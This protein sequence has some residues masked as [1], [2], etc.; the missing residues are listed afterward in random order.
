QNQNMAQ[1]TCEL[2]LLSCFSKNID[3][4]G[5]DLV[6]ISK[7]NVILSIQSSNGDVAICQANGDHVKNLA[8][9]VQRHWWV[10]N[11]IVCLKQNGTLEVYGPCLEENDWNIVA[12]MTQNDIA[13]LITQHGGPDMEFADINLLSQYNHCAI[14]ECNREHI[15][16]VAVSQEGQLK[17]LAYYK[18]LLMESK[19]MCQRDVIVELDGDSLYFSIFKQEKRK[20]TLSIKD[21]LKNHKQPDFTPDTF[22]NV[23]LSTDL[24]YVV[25]MDNVEGHIVTIDIR[26]YIAKWKIIENSC[27]YEQ[28]HPAV[29]ELDSESVQASRISDATW[30]NQLGDLYQRTNTHASKSRDH[31]GIASKPK[32]TGFKLK[33][34][35]MT[36]STQ[37][38][39]IH[40]PGDDVTLNDVREIHVDDTA[41]Y[42]IIQKMEAPA[43]Y[44]CCYNIKDGTW[45]KFRVDPN[46]GVLFSHNSALPHLVVSSS[47]FYS[48]TV[49][50][51]Q[52]RLINKLMVYGSAGLADVLCRLNNWECHSI[53]MHTLEIGLKHR[54]LDTVL[55]FLS[56]RQ[57]DLLAL[58]SSLT[59]T[60]TTAKHVVF[61]DMDIFH[62]DAIIAL[63]TTTIQENLSDHQSLQFGQQL[64]RITLSY[65]HTLLGTLSEIHDNY[66]YSQPVGHL[67]ISA[68]K[69][70][71]NELQGAMEKLTSNI[72]FLRTLL[73]TPVARDDVVDGVEVFEENFP[74]HWSHMS[75]EAVICDGIIE[76]NIP[77]VQC[78]LAGRFNTG[79]GDIA[80]IVNVGLQWA[81]KHISERE[82]QTARTLFTNL[83][84]D[85]TSK[86]RQVCF[87]TPYKSLRD[88]LIEEL[89]SKGDL[90]EFELGM[91][92]YLHKLEA[93]YS[94]VSFDMAKVLRTDG[95]V[96]EW[97]DTTHLKDVMSQMDHPIG[98][99][100]GDLVESDLANSQT[101]YYSHMLL[102]WLRG[103]DDA[104]R[105]SVLIERL[106]NTKD[107][108]NEQITPDVMLDYLVRHNATEALLAW[109]R[110]G[111][112][113]PGLDVTSERLDSLQNCSDY[114]RN[115][116][117]D[118]AAR[119][120]VFSSDECQ[121][122]SK[123]LKRQAR[124][125]NVIAY[126]KD[127][128]TNGDS[129]VIS[130][131][132]Y[133]LHFI[134]MCLKNKL[135]PLLY[136]YVDFHR[137][138]ED[139]C[140]RIRGILTEDQRHSWTTLISFRNLG[141]CGS[142]TNI[143]RTSRHL[144]ESLF[145]KSPISVGE[146]F[147]AGQTIVALSTIMF[148]HEPM[149]LQS[150][151]T[152]T[153][154]D[155]TYLK[156]T[157]SRFPKLQLT[158]FPSTPLGVI[159]QQDL[160]LYKM[161]T[162]TT[163]LDINKLANC[164]D[165]DSLSDVQKTLLH[166]SDANLRSRYG[167]VDR[168]TF[169][170]FLKQAR[171]SFAF[172]A[173]IGSQ[174][175]RGLRTLS[176]RR[177]K[178]AC[179]QAHFMGG[180]YFNDA[181]I[182]AT[183]VAFMELLGEDSSALRLHIAL[184]RT[185]FEHK[186]RDF[187]TNIEKRKEM[188][189]FW[190][191]H[192]GGLIS[193]CIRQNKSAAKEFLTLAETAIQAQKNKNML[194]TLEMWGG[195]VEFCQI[196]KLKY[197]ELYL[198]Q[199]AKRD[200][201][202]AFLTFSQMHQYPRKQLLDLVHYFKSNSVRQ[203]LQHVIENTQLSQQPTHT[204]PEP[205]V[206][207]NI[208]SQLYSRI[209]LGR[210]KESA[211]SSS[212]G[213]A[214]VDTQEDTLSDSGSHN[215][216][217]IPFD[218]SS[219]EDDI[220]AVL[221]KCQHE[222][223]PWEKL[224]QCCVELKNPVLAVLSACY[225]E[226]NTL[227]CLC[228]WLATYLEDSAYKKISHK[229]DVPSTSWQLTDLEGIIFHLLENSHTNALA[230][231][232]AVFL[233][234]SPLVH[235]FKFCHVLYT[236]PY[237]AECSSHLELCKD[238]LYKTWKKSRNDQGC[239]VYETISWVD[240][241]IMKVT[242]W[243]LKTICNPT[244]MAH[245]LM[246][247]NHTT[248]SRH[249]ECKMPDF[250]T[251][252]RLYS[253]SIEHQMA[254]NIAKCVDMTSQSAKEECG[255]VL[256]E[257]QA[258]CKFNEALLF[259]QLAGLDTHRLHINKLLA[260]YGELEKSCAWSCEETRL[261]FYK[262]CQAQLQQNKIPGTMAAQFFEDLSAKSAGLEKAYLLQLSL[263]CLSHQIDGTSVE[264]AQT[265][266]DQSEHGGQVLWVAIWECRFEAL[267]KKL[268]GRPNKGDV[269]EALNKVVPVGRNMLP[270]EEQYSKLQQAS[271][272]ESSPVVE[273]ADMVQLVIGQLLGNG[274]IGEACA[275][276][277]QFNVYSQDLAII[278]TCIGLVDQSISLER[279]SNDMK[280]LLQ[281]S[282][283][284][285]RRGSKLRA[286][287]GLSRTLSTT[288]LSST[289]SAAED[290]IA[291]ETDNIL[292]TMETLSLHCVNGLKCCNRIINAHKIA[293]ALSCSYDNVRRQ[294]HFDVL[295][296]LLS[297][298]EANRYTLAK[299]YVTFNG[300]S[301]DKVL[302]FICDLI[303]SS[304]KHSLDWDDTDVL[305]SWVNINA[306]HE[307]AHIEP[308]LL[309]LGDNPSLIGERLLH[310]TAAFT[311]TDDSDQQKVTKV[312]R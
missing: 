298:R 17:V 256:L 77:L 249:F 4:H 160:T 286:S 164:D 219:L 116:L 79:E 13:S 173:F 283:P 300:V 120:G 29:R 60:G 245:L 178:S 38:R 128:A 137:L 236:R 163:V 213:E 75:N 94:C 158:L 281:T 295:N 106:L 228:C 194:E 16:Q 11:N 310:H 169:V 64:L 5:I 214:S 166:F 299:D 210:G 218:T 111:E 265:Q 223:D 251:L 273:D 277:R 102:E 51:Q 215:L 126:P 89:R 217:A 284:S 101:S 18:K 227:H 98:V 206:Q 10:D 110:D 156:Q 308:E 279:L 153:D 135:L 280:T 244:R 239:P 118:E 114:T 303:L 250:R 185:I 32:W 174:M 241:V 291:M 42:F 162:G 53:P 83:G 168:L 307:I 92:E 97:S 292:V 221:F 15:I 151:L 72:V 271:M 224:L 12:T 87:F 80:N 9:K 199:L 85:A 119:R 159:S 260:E 171:P 179:K 133:H 182:S 181:A 88:Y 81:L 138:S 82:I 108:L 44:I 188:E 172:V 59:D 136:H 103:W 253:L 144:T 276:S 43:K 140:N 204:E 309:Q 293:M 149:Q 176:M 148:Q 93:W 125:H 90:S 61:T 311:A 113:I 20:H 183:C 31:H 145:E 268:Q 248:F 157:I 1:E 259:A 195:V 131:D 2:P 8:I 177:V 226:S 73:K 67:E 7:D 45:K 306:T 96:V 22:T 237:M 52:E 25:L 305:Q 24:S 282:P 275:V 65:L 255:K 36:K 100:A 205:K 289:V 187:N 193:Q 240:D 130:Q 142:D 56:S 272:D 147:M 155:T 203:H 104:T 229:E 62:M 74:S 302:D 246:A 297:C 200:N 186:M 247:Y 30:K 165:G 294:E 254:L 46:S 71:I 197:P 86:L 37:T 270:D 190:Q 3:I 47:A 35:E 290:F 27:I 231:G 28:A 196:H 58:K 266:D 161:L 154:I 99:A 257:L 124:V 91:V 296:S 312:P 95:E 288:S 132:D 19:A 127:M 258:R 21:L 109:V 189:T 123:L 39:D 152:M 304:L 225:K 175:E 40:I 70:A 220:L 216:D 230:N 63:L 222:T 233:P 121:N 117:L 264:Q 76:G 180:K 69:K 208:R 129:Q 68:A 198:I 242:T 50:L 235:F 143:E 261:G 139:D 49:N 26:H 66:T 150:L 55:F 267:R 115:A 6:G 201:W 23:I 274:Q 48:L 301:Q 170:Y 207:R 134:E 269:K 232:F 238:A 287:L 84:F 141:A 54:Q 192:V 107:L 57:N 34:E 146:M 234:E 212:D 278:L 252:D 33:H 14:L 122:W 211:A 262:E 191:R 167:S 112:S 209:G 263:E 105:Q 184:G 78:Y 41:I 202:I 243:L 285:H